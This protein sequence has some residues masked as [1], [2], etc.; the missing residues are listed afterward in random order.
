M[1]RKLAGYPE[2]DVERDLG[3]DEMWEKE[4]KEDGKK[5][6]YR[7]VR[8]MQHGFTHEQLEKPERIELLEGIYGDVAKWLKGVWGEGNAK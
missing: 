2:S 6:C 7:M 3:V 8:D 4:N 1:A 5:I